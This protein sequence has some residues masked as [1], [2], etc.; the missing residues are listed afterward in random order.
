[1]RES[2]SFGVPSGLIKR[3]DRLV[4][5]ITNFEKVGE[6]FEFSVFKK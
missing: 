3:Y 4:V 6:Y 2:Y 5:L 1:M